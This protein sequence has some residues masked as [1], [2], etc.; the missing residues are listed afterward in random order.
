M[1]W[2]EALQEQAEK[3]ARSAWD[4]SNYVVAKTPRESSWYAIVLLDRGR[5]EDIELANRIFENLLLKTGSVTH[6]FV[7]TGYAYLKYGHLLTEAARERMKEFMRYCAPE[8]N[9]HQYH[10]G[11]V[12]HPLTG[13][14]GMVLAGQVLD[15][16]LLSEA[17]WAR[18]EDFLWWMD[19]QH[20]VDRGMGTYSEFNSPTYTLTDIMGAA[21]AADA[22][23]EG[24]FKEKLIE[25][26]GRFWLDAALFYHHPTQLLSGPHSR[27]YQDGCIGGGASMDIIFHAITEGKTFVDYQLLW[28]YEHECDLLD[29]AA[30]AT[31]DFHIPERARKI[32]FEK[33]F[34]YYV[35]V[36]GFSCG[37]HYGEFVEDS[38]GSYGDEK[39][40]R[41][42]EYGDNYPA[43]YVDIKSYQTAEYS[44]G[45]SSLPYA[46]GGQCNTF[47]LRYRRC[48]TPEK[49]GDTRSIYTRYIKNDK[50][51]G[52]HNY[53]RRE[54]RHR[55]STVLIEE[56]RPACLQHQNKA[57]VLYRPREVENR[58]NRSLKLNILMT[59]FADF[60]EL[61][62]G[63]RPVRSI[64][65]DFDW[66]Q[67]VYV[68]DAKVYVAFRFLEPTDLGR[69]V[70]CW[71]AEERDHL[72]ISI[73]NYEGEERDFE[74][75]QMFSVHNGFVC[76]VHERGDFDTLEDF[77]RYMESGKLQER[78]D[79]TRREILYESGGD[80]LKLVFDTE[81]EKFLHQSVNGQYTYPE[82]I[83][84]LMQG[85]EDEEF[86]PR[87]IW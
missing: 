6:S 78:R 41:Y 38:Q 23:P 85:A 10:F 47:M 57:I 35:Q 54:N 77:K 74:K 68:R 19:W 53:Y 46:D 32:A 48:E 7:S 5:A 81:R 82:R 75:E 55:G 37:W 11:N 13:W 3:S 34:P 66:K 45:T 17:G 1:N 69:K 79:G 40:I 83:R 76:E 65:M 27:A 21:M 62:I 63:D 18:I 71:L 59:H 31:V 29:A 64:P 8:A 80:V 61:H 56:G 30:T 36:N 73:Y 39:G 15:N 84:A 28:D 24:P 2:K 26:E 9:R 22:C 50:K 4:A 58:Y 51:Q 12:N 42:A 33:K 43:H 60:D 49:R 72:V 16:P 70:P 14:C 86:C 25:L 52:E 44:L 67:I 87:R 20:D